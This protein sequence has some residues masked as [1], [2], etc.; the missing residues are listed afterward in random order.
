MRGAGVRRVLWAVVAVALVLAAAA[1]GGED[2]TAA[3][4]EA[5]SSL[6]T[7]AGRGGRHGHGRVDRDLGRRVLAP[8]AR[9][10]SRPS[11]R[12]ALPRARARTTA[13]ASAT[14]GGRTRRASSRVSIVPA[15]NF[16]S[17]YVDQL[18]VTGPVESE[19]LGDDAVSFPGVVGIGLASG[20]GSTVGFTKGDAGYL[21]AARTG[22]KAV[23]TT[24]RR[25]TTLAEAVAGDV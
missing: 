18:N 25:H 11:S 3:V 12:A 7:I 21:V 2:D 5:A 19:A 16:A 23:R 9:T 22:R 15:A 17:D 6:E 20:G 8:G 4:T 14:A 13:A 24:L 10:T 1:C